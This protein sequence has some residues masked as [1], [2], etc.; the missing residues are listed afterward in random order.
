MLICSALVPRMRA[1][2]YFVMY[3]VVVRSVT[4]PPPVRGPSRISTPFSASS[5]S[6]S[7][8]GSSSHTPGL[9]VVLAAVA[10]L[11][12]AVHVRHVVSRRRAR[13]CGRVAALRQ[14]PTVRAAMIADVG[15]RPDFPAGASRR[16]FLFLKHS[17][18]R[19]AKL[20]RVSPPPRVAARLT[21]RDTGANARRDRPGATRRIPSRRDAWRLCS[22][23]GRAAPRAW[24]ATC[25][26]SPRSAR[27]TRPSRRS[28]RSGASRRGGAP[29]RTRRTEARPRRASRSWRQASRTRGRRPRCVSR[30]GS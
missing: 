5:P 30:D 25:K 10:A 27:P 26:T 22:A 13:M 3:G 11:E 17:E 6:S 14:T 19:R 21:P 29:G 9:V 28:S 4:A 24:R 8:A 2:S 15:G 16:N 7:P 20:S 12:V 1:R 23:A 18:R